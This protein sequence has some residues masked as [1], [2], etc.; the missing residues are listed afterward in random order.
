[1]FD[2]HDLA[3]EMY[4]AL[5]GD[6]SS[7]LV[8]RLLVL[9]ERLSCRVAD[10][11]I[12][13]NL[14]YRA[15]EQ[16]RDQIPAER[17]TVVRNGPDS[18]RLRPVRP[19]P[20]LRARAGTIIG[21]VGVIGRHD[22][23]EHLVHAIDILVHQ[24]GR[25]DVLCFLI[26]PGEAVDE[27]KALTRKL[28][29]ERHV[30]FV[31]PV[32][33]QDRLAAYLSTADICVDPDPFNAY[34]DRSTM[35]KMMDYMAVAKPIV[36]FD[37]TEHRYSA[38]GAAVFVPGNDERAFAEAIAALIDDPARREELGR[39]GRLRIETELDWSH[40]VGALLGVY[41]RLLPQPEPLLAAER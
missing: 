13:T 10:Q 14:S 21:F 33:D 24:L 23:G 41:R 19:V 2:H 32:Q 31:G 35:L 22:G 15:V 16:R 39:V 5:Y 25:E 26:G 27:L 34:N 11:V 40:S 8:F 18:H 17:I 3:P 4:R 37:L 1:V 20:E 9:L 36:A 12:T 6:R 29:L 7:S 38:E 30:W 28:G